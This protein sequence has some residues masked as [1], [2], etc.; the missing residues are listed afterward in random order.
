MV[1]GVYEEIGKLA[2][3]GAKFVLCRIINT[4]G[5]TPR[6]T[7]AVMAVKTDGTIIG[8]VG[9]GKPEY[10]CIMKAREMMERSP[11][12]AGDKEVLHFDLYPADPGD[13]K[14]ESG[15]EAGGREDESEYICG[16]E[17]D[18]ELTV[19]LPHDEP[20]RDEICEMARK[21]RRKKVYIFGGGHVAQA[22]VPVLAKVEFAPVVYEARSEFASAK[23]FP[24]AQKVICAGFG[25]IGEKVSLEPDD[26]VAIM[27]RGHADDYEVLKQVLSTNVEYIGLMGSRSKRKII[28]EKLEN[29]GFSHRDTERIHN[30]I[31]LDI[32]SETPEEIAISIAAELIATRAGV[33][34]KTGGGGDDPEKGRFPLDE[35]NPEEEG[36]GSIAALFAKKAGIKPKK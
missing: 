4:N 11:E 30:P 29:D 19:V 20:L 28:F 21:H 32:G 12:N 15:T 24:E 36:W 5:S 13:E 1:T 34:K 10:E 22:L 25:R 3:S 26:Y 14:K 17:M 23:L 31:G 6:S 18:I 8:S 33:G 9:G 16:G 27:T 2:E 7:G 35:G